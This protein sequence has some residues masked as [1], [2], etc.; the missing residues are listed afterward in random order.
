MEQQQI[1][2]AGRRGDFYV[3]SKQARNRYILCLLG[4]WRLALPFVFKLHTGVLAHR[5]VWADD[6]G[7][8]RLFS[9]QARLQ[10][11]K[12]SKSAI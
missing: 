12:N 8:H 9:R 5:F 6:R 11:L 1:S 3:S 2:P 4:G 7:Q 10:K